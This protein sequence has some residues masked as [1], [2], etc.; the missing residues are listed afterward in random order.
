MNGYFYGWYFKSQ[1]D[2]QTLAVIPAVHGA[3]RNRTCS[4]QFVTEDGAWTVTFPGDSFY[5]SKNEIRIGENRFRKCGLWLDVNRLGLKVKGHLCFEHLS[6]LQYDIMGPFVLVPFME[7]RHSVYSMRHHVN[8]KL[9][10]N[11]KDY[12]FQNALGYWEGDRGHSFPKEYA[13]TQCFITEPK[14]EVRGSLMLSVAD[15]PLADFHFTGIIGIV[16]WQGK[17]YRFATYLGARVVQ[18][19][20]R[21]L[22]IRQGN[23]ELEARLFE[24][25]KQALR[26]PIHGAMSRTIHESATCKAFY[27][28]RIQ[29][30]TVFS[31]TTDQASFEYEY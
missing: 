2:T 1:S 20:N 27:R 8:G 4:I 14:G 24:S 26:A 31:F 17:E 13:W 21:T 6:P 16:F 29:G 25:T 28:F 7:C 15:I 22:L 11:G 9:Q 30:R 12:I 18:K 3:G 19:S 23:M 5:Q 10:I